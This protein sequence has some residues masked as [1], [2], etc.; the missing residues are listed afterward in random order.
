VKVNLALKLPLQ[1]LSS[2]YVPK[3]PNPELLFAESDVMYGCLDMPAPPG[4]LYY[5]Q[6]K[7]V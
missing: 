7:T 5:L 6:L 1:P 3:R 4:M 2:S